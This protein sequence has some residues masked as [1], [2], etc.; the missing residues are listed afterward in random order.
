MRA[1]NRDHPAERADGFDC[2][3]VDQAD[4]FVPAVGPFQNCYFNK[5]LTKSQKP[6]APNTSPNAL[7]H[8]SIHA[9]SMSG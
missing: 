8:F 5:G 9:T 7:T 2:G 3:I 6:G 4:R 1:C